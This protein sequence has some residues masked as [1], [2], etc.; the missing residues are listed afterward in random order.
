MAKQNNLGTAIILV[1]IVLGLFIFFSQD[2]DVGSIQSIIEDTP[3]IDNIPSGI[4]SPIPPVPKLPEDIEVFGGEP[5][6]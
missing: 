4:T 1:L 3:T 5:Q 2:D 6:T